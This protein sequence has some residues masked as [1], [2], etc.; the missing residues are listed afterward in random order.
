[1]K[2]VI[3]DYRANQE[4][5]KNLNNLGYKTIL[6]HNCKQVDTSLSGH[7][8]M[9][10]CKLPDNTYVCIPEAFEYYKTA[11]SGFNINLV[12]GYTDLNSN[13]PMD[14]AYNVAWIGDYAI[15]N[16]DYTDIIVK[17]KL[18]SSGVDCISVSQ[19]YSKCNI[20]CVSNNAVITSD[21]GIYK[22]LKDVKD[23][24]VLL[25]SKGNIDI[26]GWSEGFIGGASGR[27]NNNTL[28]FCGNLS[29][30]PDFFEITGFC[31]RYNVNC[32]S[33]SKQRLMDLG[34]IISLDDS[35]SV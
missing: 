7:P 15:H 3:I 5:I 23:I 13:Y 25:I 33:L 17:N 26:F 9:Q 27:L 24:D 16:F 20:C 14:I 35:L 30:H 8:D 34:T 28:A 10:I 12:C 31:S 22:K 11:L 6:S 19:G 2:C 18:I 32:I 1:M 21:N 29:E 4:I